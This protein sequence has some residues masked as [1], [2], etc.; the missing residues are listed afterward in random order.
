MSGRR[1][2]E[3]GLSAEAA[4]ARHYEACGRAIAASR[5]R[6]EGG[7]IDLVVRDGARLIFIEVKQAETHDWAAERLSERQMDRI[8]AAASEFIGTEPDGQLSDVTFDVALVD[9]AGRI[10]IREAAFGY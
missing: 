4:V 7:E 6:G 2:Y 8:Y 5:W 10:Q 9:A 3:N 1:S